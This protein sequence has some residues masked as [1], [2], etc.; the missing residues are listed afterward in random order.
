MSNPNPCIGKRFKPGVSGNPKGRVKNV[1]RRK[2]MED[3][4]GQERKKKLLE[5]A[6]E[7]AFEGNQACIDLVLGR[8]LPPAITD[9]AVDIDLKN[10]THSERGDEILTALSEKRITPSQAHMLFA[11]LCNNVKLVEMTEVIER[12]K[13]LEEAST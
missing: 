5:L 7:R 3:T 8:C 10:K 9:D 4:L 1:T 13:A 12:I 2:W 6:I 11:T